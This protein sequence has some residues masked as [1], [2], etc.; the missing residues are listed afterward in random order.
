MMSAPGLERTSRALAATSDSDPERTP[1]NS[2][3]A[4]DASLG[5]AALSG[6]FLHSPFGIQ[7]CTGVVAGLDE[8]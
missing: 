5:D 7:S 1:T 4:V 2:G 8:S 6:Q 3:T